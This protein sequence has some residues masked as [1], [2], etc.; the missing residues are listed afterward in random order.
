MAVRIYVD[1][2]EEK[3][4]IP[5]MLEAA[6][7]MVIRRQLPMGDYLISESIVIERKSAFDFARSLFDGRLFEQASRMSEA[8]PTV[9]YIIEGD[10]IR[11]RRFRGLQKQLYSALTTLILDYDVRVIYTQGPESTAE[12]LEAIARR[13]HESGG[14]RIVIHKKPKLESIVDWQLYILQAFP[15]IGPRTAIKI[16][17]RFNTLERFCRASM[18]ELSTIPGLGE[19]KAE[20]IRR[21]LI[22]PYKPGARKKTSTLDEYT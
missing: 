12:V 10:P 1:V 14:G 17:E 19:R 15:K 5:S 11:I 3:T 8:Y 9:I 13:T 22:T 2:R 18:S 6:G 21:I 4:G 7:L 20:D 16:L